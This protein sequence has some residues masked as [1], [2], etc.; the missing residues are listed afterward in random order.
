M[1]TY[2]CMCRD[3]TW[4]IMRAVLAEIKVGGNAGVRGRRCC[5]TLPLIRRRHAWMDDAVA[6]SAVLVGACN[7]VHHA[8]EHS[9][10]L[11]GT[12]ARGLTMTPRRPCEIETCTRGVMSPGWGS[13][14]YGQGQ[15]SDSA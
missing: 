12:T 2:V 9:L 3:H 13:V 4:D 1:V 8:V 7:A 15:Q 14:L 6:V 5:T 11:E 10:E